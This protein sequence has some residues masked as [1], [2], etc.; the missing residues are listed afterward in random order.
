MCKTTLHILSSSSSI[1]IPQGERSKL[2][3]Y[4]A[5][6]FGNI[7]TLCPHKQDLSKSV[8][9]EWASVAEALFLHSH[10][11]TTEECRMKEM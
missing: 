11:A 10:R 6:E 7:N 4:H 3:L 5:V 9:I 2:K 8:E 1:N